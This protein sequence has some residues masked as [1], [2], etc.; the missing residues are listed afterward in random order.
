MGSTQAA[1]LLGRYE[2]VCDK[3]I[4]DQF[5]HDLEGISLEQERL[6]LGRTFREPEAKAI[7]GSKVEG[8]RTS[9]G[10]GCDVA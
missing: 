8:P 2:Q 3:V 5:I 10:A 7:N 9:S 6:A 1:G 4:P